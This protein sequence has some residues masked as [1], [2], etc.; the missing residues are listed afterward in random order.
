MNKAEYMALAETRFDALSDLQKQTDFNAFNLL[1]IAQ[2]IKLIYFE[3]NSAL[4]YRSI[5][6]INKV[7]SHAEL[8][9]TMF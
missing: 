3:I 8:N 2:S 9:C 1:Q 7:S 5:K 4:R 6:T